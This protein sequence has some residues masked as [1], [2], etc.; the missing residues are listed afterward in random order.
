MERVTDLLNRDL[1]PPGRAQQD[2]GG[3]A[4]LAAA[5]AAMWAAA[6]ALIP[7]TVVVLLAWT[8]ERR[9]GAPAGD[10][11]R[12]AASAWLLANTAP[13]RISGSPLSLIPL[14]LG[15]LPAYLLFRSGI[16]LARSQGVAALR[17]VPRPAGALAGSYAVLAAVVAGA[18][19]TS[20][21][22]VAPP[23]AFL[24]ALL[25]AGAVGGAGVVHGAELWPQLWAQLPAPIRVVGHGAAVA[26]AF[27]LGGG[28]VVA[29]CAL[30]LSAGE[31]S[32]VLA[33][34]GAG[35]VGAIA[36]FLLT[37]AYVPSA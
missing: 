31:A 19:S 7:I 28:A 25:L 8:A 34:L 36:V 13:L 27:V 37:V 24:A 1:P 9:S 32:R 17:A 12:I 16:S 22:Q 6:L 4:V 11:L 15:A 21:V 2:T 29:G 20:Q 30:A 26:V 18:A 35:T 23:R 14:G 5:S 10:A 3:S 33:G